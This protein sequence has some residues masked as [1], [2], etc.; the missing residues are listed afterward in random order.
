MF[1]HR[2][3]VGNPTPVSMRL[4]IYCNQ[5]HHE[6]LNRNKK[7]KIIEFC[8]EYIIYEIILKIFLQLILK[9]FLQLISYIVVLFFVMKNRNLVIEI[10]L[11]IKKP[12][13]QLGH[14]NV[15]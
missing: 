5:K 13:T 9:I 14:N 15:P 6:L 1:R 3:C 2:L 10:F 8:D 11:H 7:S 4:R 12:Q